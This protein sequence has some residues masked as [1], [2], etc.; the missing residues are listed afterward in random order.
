MMVHIHPLKKKFCLHKIHIVCAVKL[1]TTMGLTIHVQGVAD[2][3]ISKNS[4][5]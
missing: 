1:G 3:I 5:K 4:L 2:F